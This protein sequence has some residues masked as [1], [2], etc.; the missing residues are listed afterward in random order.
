MRVENKTIPSCDKE[1]ENR[2][3]IG[4]QFFKQKISRL[5]KKQALIR[6]VPRTFAVPGIFVI[7][8]LTWP[9]MLRELFT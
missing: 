4:R 2:Q 3:V 1:A 9:G 5:K 8:R 6:L 7:S